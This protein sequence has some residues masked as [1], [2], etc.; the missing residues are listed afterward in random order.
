MPK[1]KLIRIT[2][3][4]VSL[5]TL[6]DGQL[7]F[8]S[9]YYDVIGISSEDELLRAVEEKEKVR[10]KSVEMTRRISP[11]KDLKAVSTLYK[12]FRK[13]KPLIV[14]T[15]TPKAG[16]VGMLAAK[17]A[18]VPFRLHTIA[19]LPLLEAR[20]NKRRL[21][22][23]VERATYACAT[24]IY[25]NS[26]KMK[27]II[28][29]NKFCSDNK[30]KVLGQGSTNGI[31]TSYFSINHFSEEQK[32]YLKNQLK[33][34]GDE[35]VYIFVGRLVTDKGINELV[36]AFEELYKQNKKTKLL[37]VGPEEP[38]RDPLLPKTREAISTHPG[39]ISVGHQA[40][41]RLY[42]AISDA[43]VFPSYREGFPNVV[44]QAGAM[45]LPSIVTNINGC[46]EIIIDGIN[47]I[48]V[49]SKSSIALF[50]AMKKLLEDTEFNRALK[51]N[52][53][54]QITDRYEQKYI[55]NEILQEYQ[56][57]EKSFGNKE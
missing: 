18:G 4:P 7:R 54:T 50:D 46:N 39:I 30:L 10:V 23:A 32:W 52:A 29:N 16:T 6:L 27:E 31:N 36:V 3:V 33:I 25:P 45:Q 40:D 2:T 9:D 19:G 11:L 17:L 21:L 48:I 22:E 43:L 34:E 15:H 55:W 57:L 14:H 47:G 24:H 26:V 20:G 38:E 13:E 28:L 35:F 37:L 1:H 5:H 42:Y 41:V 8:M 56:G 53:R 12:I 44:M 49:P 51:K